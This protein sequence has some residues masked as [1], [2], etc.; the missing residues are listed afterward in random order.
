MK[1]TIFFLM[2]FNLP[3]LNAQS[4][5]WKLERI[6]QVDNQEV[7]IDQLNNLY[8]IRKGE[9]LKLN[10]K[11]E[12]LS[13]YSNKLIGKE[14]HVDVTNPMKVV[15]YSA[16]QMRVIVLDSRLGEI[17]EPIN[18]LK[19]GYEQITLVATSHSNCLWLYDPIN[20]KL[21]RLTENL[22][23]ER[24]SLSLSQMLRLQLYP[25]DLVEVNNKVYL[26]DPN[27]GVFEFDVFGNYLRKIPIRNI[28]TLTIS[29]NRLFY[30]NDE[31]LVAFNLSNSN[32]ENVELEIA[33]L[34]T[35]SVNRDRI[36]VPTPTSAIIYQ[37]LR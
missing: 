36:V 7:L 23:E 1:W 30:R 3:V 13:R 10:Q 5:K 34:N 27:H 25:T 11:G 28:E 12:E 17:R 18:L 8:A 37:A 16:D 2:L 20:F 35:F 26:T 9:V 6:V 29:D 19:L 21:I 24:T 22:E 32:S 31:Q 33:S 4:V 14:I 15:L